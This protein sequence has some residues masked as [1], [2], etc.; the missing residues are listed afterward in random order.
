MESLLL[1]LEMYGE[2]I[3]IITTILLEILRMPITITSQT[4]TIT[5]AFP[6]LLHLLLLLS[7]RKCICY[8]TSTYIL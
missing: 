8:V 1:L 5:I 4:I 3:A 6:L 7:Q 2:P